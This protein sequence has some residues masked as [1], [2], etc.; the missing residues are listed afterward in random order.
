MKRILVLLLLATLS[1]GTIVFFANKYELQEKTLELPY[2]IKL[3]KPANWKISSRKLANNPIFSNNSTGDER[4]FISIFAVKPDRDYPFDQWLG[5]T[6]GNQEFLKNGQ[7]TTYN[8]LTAYTGS[9]EFY[10]ENLNTIA[11]IKRILLKKDG[12]FLDISL[13]HQNNPSCNQ[14]FNNILKSVKF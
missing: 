4:C 10:D 5:T 9:Y 14:V 1:L 13:S 11:Q 6:I 3:T 7:E 8:N 2:N 12:T